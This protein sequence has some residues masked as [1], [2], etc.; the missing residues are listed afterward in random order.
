MDGLRIRMVTASGLSKLASEAS[1]LATIRRPEQGF[2]LAGSPDGRETQTQQISAARRQARSPSP[3]RRGF[4]EFTE[5]AC[6]AGAADTGAV[7]AAVRQP[8]WSRL[9]PG[10]AAA[11]PPASARGFALAFAGA[12]RTCAPAPQPPPPPPPK[13]PVPVAAFSSSSASA[14]RCCRIASRLVHRRS[15]SVWGWRPCHSSPSR[16]AVPG[17]VL[18]TSLGWFSQQASV[19]TA[20]VEKLCLPEVD[21]VCAGAVHARLAGSAA[22]ASSYQELLRAAVDEHEAAAA[23]AGT[24]SLVIG[25]CAALANKDAQS[26]VQSQAESCPWPRRAFAA[27]RPLLVLLPPQAPGGLDELKEVLK[28]FNSFFANDLI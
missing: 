19:G 18:S 10:S 23:S 27:Q 2:V 13:P 16:S 4:A 21:G 1:T 22:A 14:F 6:D 5:P 9:T 12:D 3:D 11:P 20:V 15:C 28:T 7:G 8:A 24:A 25:L 26:C 17:Q